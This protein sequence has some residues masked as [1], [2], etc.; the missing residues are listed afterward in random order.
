MSVA[1]SR[2]RDVNYTLAVFFGLRWEGVPAEEIAKKLEFDS[3]ED[4]HIQLENWKIPEWL[5]RAN[6][7]SFKQRAREKSTPPHPRNLGPRKE[8]PSTGD[9]APLFRERIESLLESV[10]LLKH[11][12]EGL[13]GR[14]FVRQDV[15]TA[16]VL[17]PWEL[18]SEEGRAAIRKQR[19]PDFDEDF[20]EPN[21]LVKLPGGVSLWPSE[22]EAIV[23]GVYALADGNIDALLDLLHP[24]SAPVSAEAREEIRQC[25][26]GSRG[27]GDKRDGLKVLARQLATW[28]RGSEVRP[29][30][31]PGLSKADHAYACRI[32]HYRKQGL[33]DEEIARKESHRKKYD[34]TSYSTK[35]VTKLG[36]LGLSWP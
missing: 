34:G 29:G 13:R 7:S 23:I 14:Q 9:A 4:M 32:T 5:I 20:W 31:P 33:T 1:K 24:D 36:D 28:I 30:R 3:V 16:S 11:M 15:E 35:D 6:V 2:E 19:G 26:E 8:L 10:E 22:T 27:D 21:S 12:D 17:F 25:I 18:M